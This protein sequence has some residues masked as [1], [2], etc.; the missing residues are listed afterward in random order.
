MEE[1]TLVT[2]TESSFGVCGIAIQ[3]DLILIEAEP[4]NIESLVKQCQLLSIPVWTV[5]EET[6]R[7]GV[8]VK[9]DAYDRLVLVFAEKIRNSEKVSSLTAV[10]C[11][12]KGGSK[13]SGGS[14]A[15]GIVESSYELLA[16]GG[17]DVLASSTGKK[18]SMLLLRPDLVEKAANIIHNK[19]IVSEEV[20]EEQQKL[21]VS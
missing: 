16:E 14:K 1:G 21:A 3:K 18:Y 20:L 19:F 15:Q 5:I 6:N 7:H 13:A 11:S 8:V 17:I 4:T 2:G 10:G 12:A 9:E